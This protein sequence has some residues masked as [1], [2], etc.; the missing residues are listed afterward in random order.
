MT[1]TETKVKWYPI[2]DLYTIKKYKITHK[3]DPVTKWI[4]LPCV[5]KIK[6]NDTIVEVGRS[7]TCKKHGGAEKV[8]KALVNLLDV[9]QH[10]T[11]VTKTKRWEQIRLRHRPNSSNIKIGIIKTNAIKKTYLQEALGKD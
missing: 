4:R 1:S 10:N 5:Y 11:S 7:D 9:L 3:K 6:I 2:E 8:R